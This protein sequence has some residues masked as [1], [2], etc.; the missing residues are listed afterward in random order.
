MSRRDCPKLT[1]DTAIEE[2]EMTKLCRRMSAPEVL[3][4]LLLTC[5]PIDALAAANCWCDAQCSFSN[6]TIFSDRPSWPKRPNGKNFNFPFSATEWNECRD[7][8]AGYLHGLDLQGM[9][10]E[11]KVCGT[12]NCTSGYWLGTRPKRGGESRDVQ[13]ACVPPAPPKTDFQYSPKLMCGAIEER[14]TIVHV[15]S[16]ETAINIHNPGSATV[17]IRY[18]VAVAGAQHDGVISPYIETAIGADGAQVYSCR[19]LRSLVKGVA[20]LLDGF[21]VIES[22]S[23]LDVTAYYTSGD[24]KSWVNAIEVET[25]KPHDIPAKSFTC[26]SNVRINLSDRAN[27]VKDDGNAPQAVVP[28]AAWDADRQWMNYGSDA[29][30]NYHYKL[31]FCSCRGSIQ[32]EGANAKSDNGSAGTLV[33]GGQSQPLFSITGSGNFRQTDAPAPI[34]GTPM[35]SAGPGAMEVTVNNEGLDTGLSMAGTLIVSSG[36]AGTCK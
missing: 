23:P 9:A 24:N 18:K 16:Y 35:S 4:I 32:F 11:R 22:N 27:W 1:S 31:N 2:S 36:Y 21:F 5:L 19:Y 17:D 14:S 10:N 6:G 30:G 7:Y 34:S 26:G 28:N 15:G 25:Y 12:V 20:P 33:L 3:W 29:K 13:T 8:C